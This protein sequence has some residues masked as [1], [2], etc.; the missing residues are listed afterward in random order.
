VAVEAPN[1]ELVCGCCVEAA[2]VE[3][4]SEEVWGCWVLPKIP[5]LEPNKEAPEGAAP[6]GAGAALVLVFVF[7]AGAP[8]RLPDGCG[9]LP[10]SDDMVGIRTDGNQKQKHCQNV[11]Y[12]GCRA[13]GIVVN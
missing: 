2:G 3:P 6:V 9:V 1:K 11:L 5:G 10:K 8:K 7:W 13:S 12:A 4:K